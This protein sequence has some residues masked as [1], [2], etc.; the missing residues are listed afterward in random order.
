MLHVS[1]SLTK[2][3]GVS[4]YCS[5]LHNREAVSILPVYC[6]R[7]VYALYTCIRCLIFHHGADQILSSNRSRVE[8]SVLCR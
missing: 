4:I 2:P 1:L 3:S 7:S 6:A 5:F 8:I